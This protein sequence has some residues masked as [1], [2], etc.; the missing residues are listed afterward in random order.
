MYPS[1]LT[2]L[3]PVLTILA[4]FASA[5]PL[6]PEPL[7]KLQLRKKSLIRDGEV[8]CHRWAM[9][10][11]KLATY[12]FRPTPYTLKTTFASG[13]TFLSSSLRPRYTQT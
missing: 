9:F 12:S 1:T 3:I 5:A 7:H 8:S 4:T 2:S 6:M 13:M 11:L 10:Y